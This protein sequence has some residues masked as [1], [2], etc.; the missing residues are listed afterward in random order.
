MKLI[1]LDTDKFCKLNML[2]EVT[3]P[4]TLDRS[5]TPTSDGL[6]STYIFG[7]S[8]QDRKSTFAYI[9][10]HCHVF[11][12]VI[13]KYIR[14]MDNRIEGVVAGRI[15]V[16]I[17]S[18]TGYLIKDDE[19]G[20]TGIDFLYNNWN[21]IKWPKNDS[22]M[23]SDTIDVLN[24]Y[25]KN[26]IF[27]GKQIVC[28]AFYRDVNLQSSKSGRP[29]IHKI[30]IPYAKL[31][32]LASS[33]D[34]GDFTFNL[35]YTKFMIQ[36]TVIEIY[37]Y[38]KNRV[39]KKRGLIKQNL[40]GKST[41][42]ASRLVITNEEFTKNSVED[43]TTTFYKSGVPVSYCMAMAAPFFTGWIQNFFV[44]AFEEFAHKY[45][46]YDAKQ[47]KVIYVELKDPMIQF[48][49]EYIHELMEDYLH[50]YDHRFDP[51]YLETMDKNFPRITFRFR[52]Y[53]VNDT[54]FD[55][56]DPTR[57]LNQRPFTITDLMYLAAVDIC[58]DK[59][60]YITRYPMSDHLG[61]F[62][63]GINV[64]ST[65]VTEEMMVDGKLYKHYPKVEIGKNAQN[66][67]KEVLTLSNVYLKAIGGD[68]DGD[69]ITGKMV[70]SQEAN[71]EAERIMRSLTN[72]LGINGN[73]VRPSEIEAIQTLYCMS[74][75]NNPNEKFDTR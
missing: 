66:S 53:S 28:P 41:D 34:N 31:I 72:I 58:E 18:K 23:R 29:S 38:F 56:N 42:Y 26:E 60:I 39:E 30:N 50:S 61:I 5:F 65:V 67:F 20:S 62:P 7:I 68:F 32:Q 43:M 6:L 27:M 10:L 1:L 49:D 44:R 54:D 73:S 69:Q 22:K 11:H 63:T 4:I 9:N 36:K 40:L 24:A 51:I 15:K 8:T 48:S 45:P 2:K 75:W 59:H 3:N 17:D 55:P 25:T 71:I 64:L 37:D 70:F 16:K 14:R 19:S 74:R 46:V 13:Y 57:L 52:G 12:P 47:K 21:K 33:L 35:N